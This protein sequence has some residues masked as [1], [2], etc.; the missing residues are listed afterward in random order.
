MTDAG[1]GDRLN[2]KPDTPKGDVSDPL[3]GREIVMTGFR[4]KD[5]IKAIEAKGGK[6]G[7]SVKGHTRAARE[8]QR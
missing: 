3:Y 7:S 1:M 5:L 4:D 8:R 6:L 2:F